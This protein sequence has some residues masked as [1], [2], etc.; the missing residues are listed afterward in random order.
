MLFCLLSLSSTLVMGSQTGTV[1]NWAVWTAEYL[2]EPT[3]VFGSGWA[4]L[5]TCTASPACHWTGQVSGLSSSSHDDIGS[6]FYFTGSET[7]Y[8][9]LSTAL[10]NVSVL[11]PSTTSHNSCSSLAILKQ[12][13]NV[14]HK[15][16]SEKPPIR[17]IFCDS[18][19]FNALI[20]S[21]TV[22]VY[23]GTANA[24]SS[25]PYGICKIKT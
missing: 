1:P 12:N 23:S 21:I 20:P 6:I 11:N 7:A 9:H 22:E 10:Q 17:L 24:Q 3:G 25:S 13:I 8:S 14:K 4:E 5:L 19:I 18:S 2:W 15:P 16:C